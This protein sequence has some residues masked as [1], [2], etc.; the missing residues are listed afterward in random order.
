MTRTEI[1]NVFGRNRRSGDLQQAL[2]LLLTS[3][4]ARFVTTQPA[5]G[6]RGGRRPRPGT[7]LDR[8]R[9]SRRIQP[10]RYEMTPASA[11][12]QL[13]RRELFRRYFVAFS[14]LF[15]SNFNSLIVISLNSWGT[16]VRTG[17]NKDVN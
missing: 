1:S 4:K 2:E 15:F 12:K 9:H 10:E 8:N 11:A 3:G 5:P 16:G 6:R 13:P 14:E 17:A 7:R